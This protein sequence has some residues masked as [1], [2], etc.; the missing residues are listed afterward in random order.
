MDGV[1]HPPSISPP[2]PCPSKLP[3]HISGFDSCSRPDW[4][5]I[6]AFGWN[7]TFPDV[8]QDE[9]NPCR[10]LQ[11]GSVRMQQRLKVNI[12]RWPCVHHLLCHTRAQMSLNFIVVVSQRCSQVLDWIDILLKSHVLGI[13][14]ILDHQKLPFSQTAPSHYKDN[15]APCWAHGGHYIIIT[16]YKL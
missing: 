2:P 5:L 11:T 15:S 12:F 16:G 14:P 1:A 6:W 13:L 4:S 9:N 10:S 7:S 3:P 8:Q